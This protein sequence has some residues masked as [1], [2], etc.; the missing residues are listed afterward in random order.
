MQ[1]ILDTVYPIGSI[2]LTL[3]EHGSPA[4]IF[5]GTWEKLPEG[6]ALWTASSGAG[7]TIAAGLPNIT[8]Y[9]SG[10]MQYYGSTS[11]AFR[12]EGS[13]GKTDYDGDTATTGRYKFDANEGAKHWKSTAG[14]IYGNSE[15][16]QPPAYKVYAYKRV[17]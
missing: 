10:T 7:N 6:K 11:G 5:G 14:G 17:S 12:W 9:L 2:Y 13:N 4:S 16:V 3:N 8:G 15:T 1:R